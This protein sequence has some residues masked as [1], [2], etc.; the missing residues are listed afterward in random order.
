MTSYSFIFCSPDPLLVLLCR[1][2]LDSD[3][4]D[5]STLKFQA[6]QAGE[7]QVSIGLLLDT[8]NCGLR[9]RRECRERFPDRS[10]H[11]SRHVLD[12]RAV[13]HVGIAN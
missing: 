7:Y 6:H 13:M 1:L 4:S 2:K 8:Q 9:M 3:G 10:R 11:A 5:D 12:A